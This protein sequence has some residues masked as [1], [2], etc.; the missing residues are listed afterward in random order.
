VNEAAPDP[1]PLHV[2]GLLLLLQTMIVATLEVIPLPVVTNI[3]NA[4]PA[5][6]TTIP[7]TPA[8]GIDLLF[9]PVA[10]PMMDIPLAADIRTTR[11]T[12][13]PDADLTSHIHLQTDTAATTGQ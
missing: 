6:T 7:A 9:A 12:G 8:I 13:P 4:L 10:L 2:V 1:L 11:T 3:A 5:V